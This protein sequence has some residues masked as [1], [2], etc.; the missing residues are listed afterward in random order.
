MY[1]KH[2]RVKPVW[3]KELALAAEDSADESVCSSSDGDDVESDQEEFVEESPL[4]S[5]TSWCNLL[6]YF[7]AMEIHR[8]F[9]E[10]PFFQIVFIVGDG[11]FPVWALFLF[12]WLDF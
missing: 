3:N 8:S 4:K 5:S 12:I 7:P 9:L 10:T 2:K 1:R 6:W 11:Y